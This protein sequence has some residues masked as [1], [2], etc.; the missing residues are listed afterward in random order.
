[1]P[2]LADIPA[3]LRFGNMQSQFLD[4]LQ[5]LVVDADTKFE[6]VMLWM[7]DTDHTVP[8]AVLDQLKTEMETDQDDEKSDVSSPSTE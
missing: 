8:T 5:D 4:W 2:S 7:K 1:M 3:E 6:L